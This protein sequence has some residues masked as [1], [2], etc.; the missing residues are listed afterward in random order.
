VRAICDD[1]YLFIGGQL[2]AAESARFREHLVSCKTCPAALENALVLDAIAEEGLTDRGRLGRTIE[3]PVVTP[4]FTRHP[5][6]A[7]WRPAGSAT[8]RWWAAGIWRQLLWG[9]LLGL[10]GATLAWLLA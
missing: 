3:V 8:G 2:G 6:D 1:L 9:A 5:A 10:A 7:T 4:A